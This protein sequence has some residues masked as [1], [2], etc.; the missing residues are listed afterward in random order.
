MSTTTSGT[1]AWSSWN[2]AGF[3]K[4]SNTGVVSVDT[5]SYS[6]S[7]HTHDISLTQ[8]GT[9]T[10]NL[11][12]D[13]TYTLT[14]GG[15]S[16]AF[17]TPPGGSGTGYNPPYTNYT[18]SSYGIS[19]SDGFDVSGSTISH[20]ILNANH[21]QN[22]II[23]NPMTW[24]TSTDPDFSDNCAQVQ[25]KEFAIITGDASYE[26]YCGAIIFGSDNGGMGYTTTIRAT[27]VYI[28]NGIATESSSARPLHI[29]SNG[30]S[31]NYSTRIVYAGKTIHNIRARASSTFDISFKL[32]NRST[33]A[34]TTFAALRTALVNAGHKDASTMCSASGSYGSSY[35]PIVG[36][37]CASESS[38]ITIIYAIATSYTWQST[39]SM[40]NFTDY[41]QYIW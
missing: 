14:A 29:Q 12:A 13:T 23:G 24:N 28:N 18:T 6:L 22:F 9:A 40:T 1:A 20:P 8:T 37:Y 27:Q 30:L 26:P 7:N 19:I 21:S 33:T 10:V 3:L 17:K 16:I 25:A 5:N 2:T 38:N 32:I 39:L 11:A 41:Q 4:T 34:C 15:K 35:R 36:I 31:C